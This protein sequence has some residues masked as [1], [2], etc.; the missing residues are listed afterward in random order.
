MKLMTCKSTIDGYKYVR[1]LLSKMVSLRLTDQSQIKGPKFFR[2]VQSVRGQVGNEG[3]EIA[4]I[5]LDLL[6][7]RHY[8]VPHVCIGIKDARNDS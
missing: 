4:R 7:C 1:P 8:M 2:G 3:Q 6:T 5:V